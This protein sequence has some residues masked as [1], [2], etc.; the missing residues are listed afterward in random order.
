M[1]A[2]NN[3][4]YVVRSIFWNNSGTVHAGAV[5]W[6]DGASG[7]AGPVSSAN[8]LVGSHAND[9]VGLYGVTPLSNGNYVVSSS[10]WDNGLTADAGAATWGTGTSGIAGAV[11]NLNSLVGTNASDQVGFS[12][13]PLVNGNYV[14]SS[15]L[16]Y[17]S[18]SLQVGAVTWGMASAASAARS[19]PSTAW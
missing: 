3:G 12:V 17:N 13:T 8:S 9:N 14:V 2:L 19:Q 5:T 6:G 1:T 18:A 16:W 15:Y 4:N 11:S 7:V 10:M